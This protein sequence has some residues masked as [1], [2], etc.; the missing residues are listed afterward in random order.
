MDETT[1]EST[2]PLDASNGP[3][4]PSP[5]EERDGGSAKDSRSESS[6]GGE[7]EESKRKRGDM[8]PPWKMVR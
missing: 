5:G 3:R 2:A 4:P 1:A 8:V 7:K 6:S